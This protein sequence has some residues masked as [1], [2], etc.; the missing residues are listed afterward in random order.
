MDA[1][2]QPTAPDL[3]VTGGGE[4]TAEQLAA[5][6]VAL[7][8]V[9]GDHEPRRGPAPWLRAAMIEGIGGRPPTSPA[10]LDVSLHRG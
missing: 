6:V 9:T 10:D 3:R 2:Q 8:P 1:E 7:T 5:L 4:P